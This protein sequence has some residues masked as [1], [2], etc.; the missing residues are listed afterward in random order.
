MV[1]RKKSGIIFSKK[2]ERVPGLKVLLP[3]GA[4]AA[5][6][7]RALL[8]VQEETAQ[9]TRQAASSA[10]AE[11]E[12]KL[13]KFVKGREFTL[14]QTIR[15]QGLIVFKSKDGKKVTIEIHTGSGKV[16]PVTDMSSFTHYLRVALERTKIN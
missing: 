4:S 10:L 5:A 7:K 11:Q 16:M 2:G 1:I 14:R 6:K 15:G 3:V 12:G 13:A 8:I 9:K